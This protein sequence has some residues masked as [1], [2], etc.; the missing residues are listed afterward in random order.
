M[1]TYFLSQKFFDNIIYIFI[2]WYTLINSMQLS[3]YN[4]F[5]YSIN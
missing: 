3:M 2:S 4:H 1:I 5:K